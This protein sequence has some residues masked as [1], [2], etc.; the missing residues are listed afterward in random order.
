M[1]IDENFMDSDPFAQALHQQQVYP[2]ESRA[3][4]EVPLN[5]LNEM[6]N[7]YGG[8]GIQQDGGV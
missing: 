2:I 3:L 1:I 5:S 6:H 8:A 7:R 4:Q